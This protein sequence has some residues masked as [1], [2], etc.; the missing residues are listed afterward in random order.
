MTRFVVLILFPLLF[1]CQTVQIPE[2]SD[3]ERCVVSVEF[4]V[5]RCHQYRVSPSVVGRV[6]E[7]VDYPIEHCE[8][9]VGFSPEA[10]VNFVLW[11]EETFQAVED[12]NAQSVPKPLIETPEEIKS[13]AVK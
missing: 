6:S 10:W 3:E 13:M 7:S 5:C 4:N 1:S 8:R 11:F 9:L 2:K 12:A